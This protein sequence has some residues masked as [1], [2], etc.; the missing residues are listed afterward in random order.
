MQFELSERRYEE[1][2]A[3]MRACGIESQRDLFNNALSLFEWAAVER[4][5]GKIIASVDEKE[6]RY[7]ELSMHALEYAKKNPDFHIVGETSGKFAMG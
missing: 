3:L 5:Q 4:S 6:K 1:L 2:Q 7:K